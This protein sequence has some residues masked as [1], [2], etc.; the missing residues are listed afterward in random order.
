MPSIAKNTLSSD[1]V[2][3]GLADVRR[4]M[5]SLPKRI[6]TNVVRR[7]LLAGAGVIRD[8]A[9]RLA[10]QAGTDSPG[11]GYPRTGSLSKAIKS[12]SR[13]VFKSKGGVPTE[14]L[15]VVIIDKNKRK[16]GKSSRS[17]AHLVEFGTRPHAVG[18]GSILEVFA[19]SK[20]KKK[21]V[22]AMHP[23]SPP[24]PFMRPAF[25]SKKFEAVRTI[26]DVTRRELGVE[27]AKMKTERKTA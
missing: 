13:G 24:Q 11:G 26:A 14:H 3:L 19:R 17:Y 22:G 2:V 15:A 23:G 1:S 9:R 16:R 5:L 12:E 4:K 18:K 27:L 7:G 21:Q 10:P 25:D 8:E 6:G 20:A